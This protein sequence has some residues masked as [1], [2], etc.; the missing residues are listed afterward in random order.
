[1]IMPLCDYFIETGTNVGSTLAYIGRTYPNVKCVS[2]EPD[3]QVFRQAVKN[4]STLPNVSVYNE[5]S[6]KFILRLGR[7]YRRVFNRKVLFWLDSHGYGFRWPLKEEVAFI[8]THFEAAHVLIDDFKVPGLDCFRY[9]EYEG[10]ECSFDYIEDALNRKLEYSVHYPNYTE[11]TSKH[12]PLCG[13]VLI[14]F[15]HKDELKVPHSWMR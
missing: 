9:A 11:R 10:Q 2:C 14:A 3:G 12:H 7:E 15:G 4:T 6:Q 1:M 13:W 5:S 8:T